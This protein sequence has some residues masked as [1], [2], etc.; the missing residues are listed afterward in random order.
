MPCKSI[1]LTQSKFME[2]T[3]HNGFFFLQ[4]TLNTFLLNVFLYAFIGLTLRHMLLPYM[5]PQD[6]T[7][8]VTRHSNVFCGEGSQIT[9]AG[10]FLHPSCYE[11]FSISFTLLMVCSKNAVYYPQPDHCLSV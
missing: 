1:A 11:G 6:H 8:N 4:S 5:L 7:K 9:P 2:M 10:K 3:E